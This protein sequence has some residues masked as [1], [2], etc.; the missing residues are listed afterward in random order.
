M[1]KAVWG[2]TASEL[3]EKIREKKKE[4]RELDITK[5]KATFRVRGSKKVSG[6]GILKA[7]VNGTVDTACDPSDPP[8]DGSPFLEVRGQDSLYVTGT[9]SE[10]M[11]GEI[12]TG[13]KV[14]ISSWESEARP[15]KERSRR[16]P[17]HR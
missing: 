6:D 8:N 12:Q 11:L 16:F 3:A 17:L 4:I 1:M 14:Q 10:L 13:Q 5:R 15:M 7:S 2:Y 9:L